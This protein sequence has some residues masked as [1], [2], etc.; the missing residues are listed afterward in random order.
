MTTKA[1]ERSFET[2]ENS[3]S[4]PLK[5]ADQIG[6]SVEK[7]NKQL[8]EA[9]FKFA[10]S[11]EEAQKILTPIF[12]TATLA[13]YEL[14][15]KSVAAL[16]ANAVAGFSY[17]Q[18]LLGAN[19]PSQVFEL[20]SAFLHKRVDTSIEDAKEFRALASKAVAEIAKPINNA[21]EK[22]LADLKAV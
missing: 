11:A 4:S 12:E 3:A 18:A 22:F 9:F 10:S 13:G 15:L 21:F 20:Q 17:L 2:I 16:H 5:V 8:T 1:S 19:S 7:G 6:A 14:S